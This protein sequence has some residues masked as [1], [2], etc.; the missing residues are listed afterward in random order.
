MHG[1]SV[2]EDGDDVNE[3]VYGKCKSSV[4][5]VGGS[6]H[7]AHVQTTTIASTTLEVLPKIRAMTI[8]A[9]TIRVRLLALLVSLTLI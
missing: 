9:T 3:D 1:E 5:D 6:E 4:D 2:V 8:V 7:K